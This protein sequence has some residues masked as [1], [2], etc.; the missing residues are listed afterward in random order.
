MAEDEGQQIIAQ[1]PRSK[2]WDETTQQIVDTIR[3]AIHRQP[4]PTISQIQ[5]DSLKSRPLGSAFHVVQ[6]TLPA[7]A[8]DEARRVFFQA[9][10]DLGRIEHP[11][12]PATNIGLEW[13]SKRRSKGWEGTDTIS[14]AR[15]AL[16]TLSVDVTSKTTIF[17]IHGGGMLYGAP[18]LLALLSF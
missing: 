1:F 12:F 8:E 3:M 18:S 13:V 14:K 4:A 5:K 10:Q 17:H 15:D 7:P 9:I 16:D 2:V 11:Y 6:D